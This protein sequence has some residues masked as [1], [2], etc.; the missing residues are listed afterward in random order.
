V[1]IVALNKEL[2]RDRISSQREGLEAIANGAFT[3]LP[4]DAYG[5]RIYWWKLG[6][7]KWM[8]RPFFGWG[9]GSVEYLFRKSDNKIIRRYASQHKDFHNS[10]LHVLVQV[11]IVGTAFLMMALWLILKALRESYAARWL[12]RDVFLFTMGAIA[13]F[14]MASMVNLRTRD[15]F[16]RF[17]VTLFGGVAYAYR[18]RRAAG[19]KED[20]DPSEE[21]T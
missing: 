3:D 11:G 13:L 2:I 18:L 17:H 20:S 14:L 21:A 12:K 7:E 9:P 4:A 10:L 15:H 1:L 6:V 8:E 5:L 19:I 16:G